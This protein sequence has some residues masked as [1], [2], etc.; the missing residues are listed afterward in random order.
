MQIR[1]VG[2]RREKIDRRGRVM[3]NMYP[4]DLHRTV[5]WAM[6]VFIQCGEII[7][8]FSVSGGRLSVINDVVH[9]LF[10][11]SIRRL[12]GLWQN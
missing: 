11:V 9:N 8:G 3:E 4:K 1:K 2:Q 5:G 12:L 6:H 7:S 10:V